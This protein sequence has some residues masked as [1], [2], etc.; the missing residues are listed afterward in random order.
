[1]NHQPA[2]TYPDARIDQVLD[3]LRTTK[4]PTGLEQR[5]AARLSQATE[6]RTQTAAA[7]SP[8]AVIL[9]AVKDRRILLGPAKL[10]TAA[11]LALLITLTFAIIHHRFATNSAQANFNSH[12]NPVAQSQTAAT[13]REAVALQSRHNL[14]TRTAALAAEGI[15]AGET[16]TQVPRGFSF[17]SHTPLQTAGVLTPVPPPNPDAIALAETLAPSRPAPPMPLTAQE[18]LIQAAT[19]PGQPIQLAELDIA[20]EPHLR[21]AAQARTNEDME[22]YVKSLLAPF[23]VADA[24]QPTT[25][26]Q[27]QEVSTVAPAEPTTAP[28]N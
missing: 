20:R 7:P 15:S 11:P 13:S 10:Y 14:P 2:N 9:R 25:F 3:A 21:A 17:G 27:S 6:A 28:I 18:K 4:P 19:R 16:T 1:M 23:A 12:S 26:P 24:L 22:R 5:I 8:I